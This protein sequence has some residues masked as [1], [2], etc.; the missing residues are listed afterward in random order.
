MTVEQYAKKVELA[1]KYGCA[2][3]ADGYEL[4]RWH[5]GSWSVRHK[6]GS[7]LDT[8]WSSDQFMY[9]FVEG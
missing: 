3:L 4:I 7:T 6:N 5:D 9:L 8:G 2:E 1:E